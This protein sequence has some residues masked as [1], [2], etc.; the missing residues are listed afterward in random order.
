MT[1]QFTRCKTERIYGKWFSQ[2]E[3]RFAIGI[4][5]QIIKPLFTIPQSTFPSFFILGCIRQEF[6]WILIGYIYHFLSSHIIY[7]MHMLT[8]RQLIAYEAIKKFVSHG[9]PQTSIVPRWGCRDA[10]DRETWCVGFE[11]FRV[12]QWK[13]TT[14][15]LTWPLVKCHVPLNNNN[16]YWQNHMILFVRLGGVIRCIRVN[17]SCSCQNLYTKVQH[18]N[19]SV[20]II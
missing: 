1:I 17:V 6:A 11:Y 12:H 8:R 2:D 20:K 5:F 14:I 4:G 3:N 10:L 7:I 18:A 15:H 19:S 16:A 9:F 13:L